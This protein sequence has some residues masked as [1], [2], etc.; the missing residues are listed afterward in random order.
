M[1]VGMGFSRNWVSWNWVAMCHQ[2][3]F[4][5]WVTYACAFDT[6]A[7]HRSSPGEEVESSP[8]ANKGT[9]VSRDVS[10]DAAAT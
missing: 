9:P 3:A 8:G 2:S 10:G 6:S 1:H 4:G 5:F 7:H